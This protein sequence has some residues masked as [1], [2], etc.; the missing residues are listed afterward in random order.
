M[1]PEYEPRN[2]QQKLGYLIEECGEVLAAAGKTIRWGLHSSNPELPTEQRETNAAW[3]LREIADLK[4]AIAFA[5]TAVY[6]ERHFQERGAPKGV[7]ATGHLS[8]EL[9]ETLTSSE[10]KVVEPTVNWRPDGKSRCADCEKQRNS[11]PVV[12][13]DSSPS[14][15][16]SKAPEIYQPPPGLEPDASAVVG[17][18]S[19][20]AADGAGGYP[21]P[22][23]GER[24]PQAAETSV[25]RRCGNAWHTDCALRWTHCFPLNPELASAQGEREKVAG[26]PLTVEMMVGALRAGQLAWAKDDNVWDVIADELERAAKEQT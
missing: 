5:E 1:K 10:A 22:A 9:A 11:P 8:L 21:S 25:V 15:P 18:E 6:Q 13:P 7:H 3:L 12:E 23:Q 20:V 19:A 14:G 16:S 4:R 17:G 26:T 2:L 24:V